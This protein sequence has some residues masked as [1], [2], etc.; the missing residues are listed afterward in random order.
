MPLDA[1]ARVGLAAERGEVREAERAEAIVDAHRHDVAAAREGGAAVPGDAALP[2]LEAA[3]VDPDQHRPPRVVRG[4]RADVE[5][6]AV[7]VPAHVALCGEA[8]ARKLRRGGAEALRSPD[9]LPARV[10]LG[11]EEAPLPDRRSRVGDAGEEHRAF[12][13][14][15]FDLA[16]PGVRD[17]SHGGTSLGSFGPG[18]CPSPGRAGYAGLA[19]WLTPAS[20]G[21]L[22]DRQTPEEVAVGVTRFAA[23][24][25]LALAAPARADLLVASSETDA[26]LRYDAAS[27]AFRGSF[28]AAGA[29]GLD[30]PRGIAVGP[31]G[32]LYVASFMTDE[33][34]RYDGATGAF[35]STSS[36][37]RGAAG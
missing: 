37:R 13:L 26:V 12:L 34:L 16:L 30:Q 24:A 23:L 6:E 33:V 5:R 11:R 19:S 8:F 9:A 3:A 35:Q 20:G 14:A 32:E 18:A 7:L 28:V 2:G 17:E 36:S 22:L 10:G 21:R 25:V 1:R 31:D 15:T 27:G 29:G 4:G